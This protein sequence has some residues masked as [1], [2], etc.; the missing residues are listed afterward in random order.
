MIEFE[1]T[2]DMVGVEADIEALSRPGEDRSALM[3]RISSGRLARAMHRKPAQLFMPGRSGYTWEARRAPDESYTLFA[4]DGVKLGRH[5]C[6]L[7]QGINWDPRPEGMR[8]PWTVTRLVMADSVDLET[9]QAGE[10]LAT[11]K[12]GDLYID[13]NSAPRITVDQ[14]AQLQNIVAALE[15][16]LAGLSQ[17]EGGG[18]A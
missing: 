11:A 15:F 10:T 3:R 7:V 8:T 17:G 16:G 14:A 6:A 13:G 18:D 12:R 9:L 1:V 2:P 5:V 4:T